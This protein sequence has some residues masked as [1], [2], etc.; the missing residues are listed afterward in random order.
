M[1][2]STSSVYDFFANPNMQ[3]LLAGLG[4]ELDPEG[5]GG[6]LGRPTTALI[7]G[8]SAQRA[9]TQQ[10][11]AGK[12][13]REA[14]REQH[15]LLLDRLGPI[16]GPD[17]VGLNGIKPAANG[18]VNIDT[19]IADPGKLVADLGGFTD[20]SQPG[21]NS[22]T[23][24]PNGSTLVNYTLPKVVSQP[25]LASE[26]DSLAAAPTASRDRSRLSYTPVAATATQT[27]VDD[28]L[29]PYRGRL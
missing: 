12:A 17:K 28:M 8:Q 7:K 20:L 6:K 16:T 9:A 29:Q 5:I 11:E 25:T 19:N 27:E 21:I 24:S 14:L 3:L 13:E 23:R 1:A 2:E 4:T 18:T 15:R 22:M 10:L 26:V